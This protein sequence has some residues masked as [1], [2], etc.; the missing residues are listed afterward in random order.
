MSSVRYINKVYASDESSV[1][2]DSATQSARQV[3][4]V[5]RAGEAISAGDAVCFD[6]SQS[7]IAQMFAIV[8]KLDSGAAN[9]S[10]FCGVAA[11]DAD[12]D[13]YV[14]VVVEGLAPDANVD[15][16]T[17]KGDYLILGSTAVG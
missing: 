4:E 12:E 6:F 17:A 1:G 9:T 7:T 5:F 14:K 8:K 16:A 3:L 11:E 13:A 2:E 15:A 10:V